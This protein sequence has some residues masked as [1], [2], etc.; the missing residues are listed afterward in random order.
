MA[1]LIADAIDIGRLLLQL[2]CNNALG[3]MNTI[4]S[5]TDL[6]KYTWCRDS[7][8]QRSLIDF[9]TVTADFFRSVLGILV[10]RGAELSMDHHLVVC[11]LRLEKQARSSQT[12]RS[13]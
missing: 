2:C 5:N 13:R 9:C 12:C 3:I 4:S 10:K 7:L 6:H 1:M 8:G 11:K